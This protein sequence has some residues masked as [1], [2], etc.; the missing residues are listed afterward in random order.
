MKDPKLDIDGGLC[1]AAAVSGL[2]M[3]PSFGFLPLLGIA[4]AIGTS[5]FIAEQFNSRPK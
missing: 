5:I 3:I 2:L 4:A 1:L